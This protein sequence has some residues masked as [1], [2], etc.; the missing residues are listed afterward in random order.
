MLLH[1]KETWIDKSSIKHIGLYYWIYCQIIQDVILHTVAIRNIYGF[2][3]ALMVIC[4]VHV[5]WVHGLV[6]G[7]AISKRVEE[8]LQHWEVFPLLPFFDRE[9]M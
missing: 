3:M 7:G 6:Y 1:I 4:H 9:W 2:N 8:I 5:V